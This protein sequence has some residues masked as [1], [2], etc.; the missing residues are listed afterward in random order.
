VPKKVPPKQRRKPV[1]AKTRAADDALREELRK[2]DL[3]KL[4][5]V[6]AKAIRPLR[7]AK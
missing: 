1:S 2:F 5:K 6:T 7:V 3:K 4:D